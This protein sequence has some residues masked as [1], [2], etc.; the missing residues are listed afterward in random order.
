[1]QKGDLLETYQ[2][3]MIAVDKG[4]QK[5]TSR[6]GIIMPVWVLLI[7]DYSTQPCL[8]SEHTSDNCPRAD[9]SIASTSMSVHVNCNKRVHEFHN[10]R[11]INRS[12]KGMNYCKECKLAAHTTILTT[13]IGQ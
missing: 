7:L 10:S 12:R 5:H 11:G 13:K 8:E 9:D 4:D 2:K 3:N 1:M 6:S